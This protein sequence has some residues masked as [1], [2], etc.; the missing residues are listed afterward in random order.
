MSSLSSAANL[1]PTTTATGNVTATATPGTSIGGI[2]FN[3]TARTSAELETIAATTSK[4]ARSALKQTHPSQY[5]KLKTS[6]TQ[7]SK[8]KFAIVKNLVE[9]DGKIEI[10]NIVSTEQLKK[11]IRKHIQ[12]ND[13]AD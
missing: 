9:K 2:T 1:A 3:A 8:T 6:L 4:F 5:A 7:G 11:T 12:S 10:G 13:M